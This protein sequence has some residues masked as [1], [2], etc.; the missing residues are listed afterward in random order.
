MRCL[1]SSQRS[2]KGDGMYKLTGECVSHNTLIPN[3]ETILALF[4]LIPL[5]L[6]KFMIF[7]MEGTKHTFNMSI[8]SL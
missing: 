6:I 8:P 4:H 1:S 3:T 2:N 7:N 5:A